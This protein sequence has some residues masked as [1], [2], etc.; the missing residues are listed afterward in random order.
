MQEVLIRSRTRNREQ[1]YR[2]TL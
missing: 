1:N 2:R